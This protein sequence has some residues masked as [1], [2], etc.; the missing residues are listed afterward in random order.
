MFQNKKLLLVLAIL[1]VLIVLAVIAAFSLGLFGKR[2][3]YAVTLYRAEGGGEIERAGE[4]TLPAEADTALRS[5]DVLR[6]GPD[7][8]SAVS[9]VAR[10][11]GCGGIPGRGERPE[12]HGV[13]RHSLR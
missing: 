10:R 11:E 2:G 8:L 6:A 5:G 13:R 1:L 12:R 4:G 7:G 9:P 3:G